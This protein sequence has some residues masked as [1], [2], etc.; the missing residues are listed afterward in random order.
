MTK[1]RLFYAWT[2]EDFCDPSPLSIEGP[3][4][5]ELSTTREGPRPK[6]MA[7]TMPQRQVP[8]PMDEELNKELHSLV[9]KYG[10]TYFH[11]LEVKPS[12]TEG[13][14][15]DGLYARPQGTTLNPLTEKQLLQTEIAHV[16][17]SDNSLHVWLSQP[18]ARK[19]VEKGWGQR[20]PLKFVHPGWVMVYAPRTKEELA[21]IEKI[22][23]A[24]IAWVSGVTVED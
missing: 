1:L 3:S 11:F 19:V 4:Y 9:H 22:V 2:Q 12:H 14:S 5:L 20:F 6:I 10:I 16:H 13:K 24:G 21:E 15:T 8:E 23:K 7:R 18:D 17:P